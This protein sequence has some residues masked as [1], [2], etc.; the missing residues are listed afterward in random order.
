MAEQKRKQSSGAADTSGKSTKNSK[1]P[2]PKTRIYFLAAFLFFWL[3]A[4]AFRLVVLQ[5]IRY[6]EFTQRASRQQQRTVEVSS[7][8]G[9]IYD[10]NGHELAMTINVDSVFAVPSEIPDQANAANLIANVLKV[11][12]KEVLAK[13]QA[14]RSFAWI[15]RKL[16]AEDSNRIRALGLKGIYFQKESKRF[17]PKRDLAAQVLGYVGLDDE[18]LGGIERSFDDQ[19]RGK[20]GKMLVSV[21]ARQ[22]SL[23][24]IEKQP[25]SGQSVVLTIDEKIQYI[26]ERELERSMTETHAEAGTVVVQDPHTGEVL[27]LAS[28]PTF[29]PN[30]F[31]TSTPQ[32]LK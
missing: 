4:I 19:M 20:P 1:N 11:E 27:A 26:A 6:G 5:V 12:P 24:R 3:C 2:N 17:Y 23:G 28:R 14:S 10:R 9:V 32:A 30:V 15:A 29:N 25:E 18:G 8:R 31:R 21:D 7:R 22:R 16:D 13:I